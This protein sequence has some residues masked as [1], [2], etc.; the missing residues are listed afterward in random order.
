MKWFAATVSCSSLLA[1]GAGSIATTAPSGPTNLL[2]I[3]L[4]YPV[5]APTSINVS[6]VRSLR[7]MNA[8]RSGSHVPNR[9]TYFWMISGN[10]HRKRMPSSVVKSMANG[11]HNTARI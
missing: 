5:L 6:P 7:R 11:R 3:A 4:R 9:Y 1:K 2:P 10:Q 8:T